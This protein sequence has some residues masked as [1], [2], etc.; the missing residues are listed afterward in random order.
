MT[1]VASS[2][3][4]PV[5]P[6]PTVGRAAGLLG[7]AAGLLWAALTVWEH[8]AG[9]Q[10]GPLAGARLAN[11]LGFTAATIGYVVMLVGLHRVR[12]AGDG[13]VARTMT[14]L[15]VSAWLAILAGQLLGLLAGV[16]NDAN[17]LLPIGGILQA[18]ASVA[19]GVAVARAVRWTGWRRWW[20]LALGVY[21]VAV[22]LIPAF[23]GHQP[24]PI[25][26]PIW[27]LTNA[28]LGLALATQA[29]RKHIGKG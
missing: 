24:G 20:P 5:V 17:P 4:I 10:S 14:G 6:N 11:Q 25:T 18:V 9:L 21:Y 15:F 8:R 3:R 28:V 26:E 19:V 2:T 23:A 16:D 7:A 22:L 13:K 1:S 29:G 27:G 12:P